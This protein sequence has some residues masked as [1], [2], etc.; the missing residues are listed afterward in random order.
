MLLSDV[1]AASESVRASASRKVKI[2]GLAELLGRAES[3]ELM[4]VVAWISGEL[5]QGRLGAGW[6]TVAGIEVEPAPESTLTV[7]AVDQALTE[8]A[9][10]AG[11]G[12][13]A[14]RRALLTALLARVTADER[15]FLIRLLT[16][17]LR[18]GALTAIVA[19]A[20]AQAADVPAELVRRAY[21]LS[22]RLPVTAT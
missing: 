20:V 6:R 8:L 10:V 4:P 17:E 16:G 13:V 21:M 3:D 19:E 14:R 12:S 22:G 7:A 9:A 5:P 2:A 1:V 18:Q 11:S 15:A